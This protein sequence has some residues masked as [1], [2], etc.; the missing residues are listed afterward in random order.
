M[1]PFLTTILLEPRDSKDAND[2]ILQMSIELFQHFHL[3][4]VQEVSVMV[5]KKLIS[6]DVQ[7]VD[8]AHN[9]I[10]F[11]ENIFTEF[12]LPIQAYKFQARYN[13]EN[14]ILQLGP[15][16]GLITDFSA[17]EDGVPHFRSIHLFC[18]MLHHGVKENGGFFYVFAYNEF[19][20]KGYCFE[21]GTWIPSALPLPDVIYNRVHSRRLEQTNSFKK[22]RAKLEQLNIPIFND[23]FLS[24]W[25]VHEKLF[26]EKQL[27]SFLPETRIFSRA[28]LM[29]FAEKFETTFIK[30]I[31]GS[32]GRNIIKLAKGDDNHYTVQSSLSSIAENNA[33]TYSI[34]QI[35]QQIKPV[36]NKRLYIIQ[37]GIPLVTNNGCVM[38]FR[39]LCHKNSTNYWRVTSIVARISAE[40]EFVTNIA[41]GGTVMKPVEALTTCMNKTDALEVLERIKDLSMQT[42]SVIS[43]L[44]SGIMGELGI[45]IGVDPNGKPWIIEVNSKP[46]KGFE[47]YQL[48]IRPSAKAIIQYCTI[49]AFDNEIEKE[50]Q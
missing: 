3:K 29:E 1:A 40:Q 44:P 10:V 34:D 41:K 42:G 22:F 2:C 48:K 9:M 6:M 15:I 16:I 28:S 46:S 8:I 33:K 4:K 38:D 21:N 37:Q 43:Q 32:Q 26:H 14:Q 18:E 30:P 12:Y 13:L 19:L 11:P 5:G 27:Q 20:N 45:D 49:L 47:E 17:N 24:K 50:E 7:I 23:R 39:V 25:E 36:L 35:Y 31:H